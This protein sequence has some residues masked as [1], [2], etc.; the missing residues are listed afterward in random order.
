MQQGAVKSYLLSGMQGEAS[1][2]LPDIRTTSFLKNNLTQVSW[3][4]SLL[5]CSQSGI[6]TH[7]QSNGN[8]K[9]AHKSLN[10]P[11]KLI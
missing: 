6:K 3:M 10:I 7:K 2:V 11:P 8:M 9:W 1:E 5:L 4:T